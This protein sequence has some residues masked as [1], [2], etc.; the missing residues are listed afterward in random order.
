MNEKVKC[1]SFQKILNVVYKQSSLQKKKLE[2]HFLKRG[3][4]YFQDA[5]CFAAHYLGYLDAQGISLEDAVASYT[6]LCSDMMR[7]QIFFKRTGKY[8]INSALVAEQEVYSDPL[9][10]QAYM[11]GLALSLFLWETHYEIYDFFRK[12]FLDRAMQVCSYLEVGPGH[13]LFLT[14]AV[15]HVPD[16]I[17]IDVVDISVAS[18][19]IT[20]SIVSSFGLSGRP[21]NYYHEDFLRFSSERKYDFI[22]MGEV[23]EHVERPQQFLSKL[24]DLLSYQGV[25][26]I[27]TCAN[28]PAI[29]HVFQFNTAEEIRAML[30]TRGFSILQDRALPVEDIPMEEVIAQ[31]VTVNYCALIVRNNHWQG[32]GNA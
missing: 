11:I 2:K 8:P 9:R 30:I 29:D 10:M 14:H 32:A 31:K 13:G 1:E 7:C 19:E 20:R 15:K 16:G 25:A 23:L 17:P 6:K 22:T 4:G 12:S 21:I 18:L 3:D 28:C 26:F 27:S 5:E 24:R